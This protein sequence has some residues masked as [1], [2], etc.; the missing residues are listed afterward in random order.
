MA[1]RRNPVGFF[2]KEDNIKL[3][4]PENKRMEIWNENEE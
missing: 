4:F 1:D 3:L 2:E